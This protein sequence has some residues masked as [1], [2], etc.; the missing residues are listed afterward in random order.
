MKPQFFGG[1]FS[2]KPRALADYDR[3]Q[4]KQEQRAREKAQQ[5]EQERQ[6]SEVIKAEE[7]LLAQ[8]SPEEYER[9]I[10]EAKEEIFT[11]TPLLRKAPDSHMVNVTAKDRVIKKLR[12][13]TQDTSFHPET[14]QDT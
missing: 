8:L 6:A 14:T 9:F 3:Q 1:L 2:F 13:H 7:E 11:E 12:E 4:E 5:Q 10:Q